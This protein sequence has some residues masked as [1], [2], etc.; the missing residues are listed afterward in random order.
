MMKEI[1]TPSGA[2]PLPAFFPDATYAAVRAA[3]FDQVEQAG[4]YGCEMNSCSAALFI[5]PCSAMVSAYFI[6]CNV[7][8]SL[9]VAVLILRLY[10]IRRGLS[11]FFICTRFRNRVR[12]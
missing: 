4:L 7:I 11:R 9:P 3:G 10:H 12:L 2:L 1:N 5:E 8:V 6:C